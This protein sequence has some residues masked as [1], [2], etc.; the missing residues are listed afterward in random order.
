MSLILDALRKLEREKEAREPGVLVVGS[1]PWGERS[2]TRPFWLAAGA[3]AALALAVF[4]GWMLRPS[5][6]APASAAAPAVTPPAV[7][8]HPAVPA[9][10]ASAPQAA[11]AP[12]TVPPAPPIRI[13]RPLPTTVPRAASAASPEAEHPAPTPEPGAPSL[14]AAAPSEHISV[15]PANGGEA[16]S[17]APAHEPKVASPDELRLSAIGRR[18][19]RP[20]ALIN[21]RL[22]F[23]GDSFDGVRVLHIGETEVELEVKG[24]RR[25]LRF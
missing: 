3:T 1:V 15:G 20:V 13:S 11:S 23:E 6:P 8:P 4:V 7:T 25:V 24:Q 19:G 2:R 16:A 17:A 12:S 18:D 5:L 9:P 21:D 14:P 22:V 10:A